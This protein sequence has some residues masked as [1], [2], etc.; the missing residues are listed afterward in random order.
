MPEVLVND[1]WQEMDWSRL[2]RLSWN[3]TVIDGSRL[4]VTEVG[5]RVRY[6]IDAVRAGAAPVFRR[7]GE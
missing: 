5:E 3:V 4:S 7:S 2:S 1:G 6:W